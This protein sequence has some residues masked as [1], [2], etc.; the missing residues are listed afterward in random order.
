MRNFR[1]GSDVNEAVPSTK[2]T[3]LHF[4]AGL[5]NEA[6]VEALLS[7]GAAVDQQDHNGATPLHLACQEG[8]HSCV[9]TLLKA[10]A[11]LTL[12]NKNGFLPIHTAARHSRVEIVNAF[13]EHGCSTDMVRRTDG[14]YLKLISKMQFSAQQY[15]WG[16]TT[17]G[18]S[19]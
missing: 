16:N 18:C 1:S 4:A 8:C 13:L 17:H 7:W 19:R 14:K 6:L 2:W 9:L 12:P 11:N 10:R 15:N 5:G 3:A